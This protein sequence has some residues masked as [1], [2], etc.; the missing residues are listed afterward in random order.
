[1]KKELISIG[2]LIVIIGGGI[3]FIFLNKSKI[4]EIELPKKEEGENVLP[5]N[6]EIL[7][8]G[9][10][11][12]SPK[13]DERISSPLKISGKIMGEGWTAFE[14]AVGSVELL[15]KSGK[16]LASAQLKTVGEWMQTQ[17]SFEA[18]LEFKTTVEGEGKLVFHNENPSG[19]P[20]KERQ[21]VLPVNIPGAL[22]KEVKNQDNAKIINKLVNFGFQKASG[23]SIDTIIIHSSYDALGTD[24]YDTA[25]LITEYKDYGVSP[26]YLINREGTIYKLVEEK[27]I[28]YHA[29]EGKVPDGRNSVNTFSIGIELMNT[30]TDNYTEAQYEALKNLLADLKKRY[31]I[32]YVLGH[33]DIAPDR[34]D[35]PWNFNM[36]KL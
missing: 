30:K 11:I 1:M 21:F 7:S 13:T 17:V 25:G 34:K 24:P 19:M 36:N 14:G 8:E 12:Y 31:K 2:I 15:E 6:E 35:D 10:V 9:I 23:R 18:S 20:E 29:G 33:K 32:K 4:V 3:F 26:H 5:V 27:N 16:K 22:E 28:A